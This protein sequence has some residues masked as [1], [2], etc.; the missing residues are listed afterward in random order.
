MMG[1]EIELKFLIDQKHFK[2]IVEKS[3]S[4]QHIVQGYLFGSKNIRV[5]TIIQD[6]T[7]I[8]FLTIKGDRKGKVRDEF[9]YAIP[10][11]EGS[12]MLESLT[13]AVVSKTRYFIK[14]GKDIW[15]IDDF[16]GKNAGL[17]IAEIEIPQEDYDIKMP[18]W[19]DKWKPVTDDDRYY[20]YYL[21]NNPY[22]EWNNEGR[23]K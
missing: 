4:R 8:S 20:N 7:K 2:I 11:E 3:T 15:E 16:N 21:A 9:E 1:K 14:N 19:M 17:I 22:T 6:G 13:T 23:Q 18:K 12:V 5:R 10:Y